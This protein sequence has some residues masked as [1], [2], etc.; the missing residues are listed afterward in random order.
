MLNNHYNKYPHKN[1]AQFVKGVNVLVTIA[2]NPVSRY[3]SPQGTQVKGQARKAA[4]GPPLTCVPLL[5]L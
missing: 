3:H 4:A 1:Q 2:L 5:G